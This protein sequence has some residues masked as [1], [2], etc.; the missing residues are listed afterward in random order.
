MNLEVIKKQTMPN[1]PEQPLVIED[2]TDLAP[3]TPIPTEFNLSENSEIPPTDTPEAEIDDTPSI[4]IPKTAKE[5]LME[6]GFGRWAT[7]KNEM[8]QQRGLKALRGLGDAA[9]MLVDVWNNP[10]LTVDQQLNASLAGAVKG[11]GEVAKW[12]VNMSPVGGLISM[13]P[14]EKAPRIVDSF[15]DAAVD[16]AESVLVKKN[17]DGTS[18]FNEEGLSEFTNKKGLVGIGINAAL[19]GT[20]AAMHAAGEQDEKKAA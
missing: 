9:M 6:S 10:D 20:N 15:V 8:I 2:D 7:E 11:A 12:S 3:V 18:S 5:R 19:A 4:E 14:G 16:S 1:N 17:K 13:I